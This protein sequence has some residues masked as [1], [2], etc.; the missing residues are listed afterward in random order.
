MCLRVAQVWD[1]MMFVGRHRM[2]AAERSWKDE[3]FELNLLDKNKLAVRGSVL[4]K[5]TNTKDLT[6]H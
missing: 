6:K 2:I 5:I 3:E 4:V 1:D